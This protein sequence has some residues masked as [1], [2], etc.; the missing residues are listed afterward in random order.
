[1]A[2]ALTSFVARGTRNAMELIYDLQACGVESDIDIPQVTVIGDQSSGKSSVLESICYVPLPR[3][4]GLVTKCAIEIRLTNVHPE[5]GNPSTTSD[6]L[7]RDPFWI[8]SVFT[9]RDSTPVKIEMKSDLE[10]AIADK[11]N[12]LSDSRYA[13]GF[14][15]ERVIVQIFATGAPNLTVIDLPGIIRTKT[16]GYVYIISESYLDFHAENVFGTI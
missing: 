10:K 16:F 14:S 11:A 12:S 15:K 4:A 7:E 2:E 13:G 3:G 8:C 9:S 6:N 1:M 5:D